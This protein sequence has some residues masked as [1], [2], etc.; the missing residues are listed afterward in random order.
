MQNGVFCCV[1]AFF[2]VPLHP[3]LKN[4][5]PGKL[6]DY[7]K[8]KRFYF[9]VVSF[10]IAS[11]CAL[12]Q[13]IDISGA[14]AIVNAA[15]Q[16]DTTASAYSAAKPLNDASA[17]PT[18][19]KPEKK[20]TKG[21][22]F[23]YRTG[24][25]VDNYLQR[26]IDTSYIGLPE[27][28]WR[29]AYTNAMV[30][31]N[32]ALSSS[33]IFATPEGPQE[34]TFSLL[35]RTTPSVDLGFYA[36]YRGFGFGY[37][38]DALHAYAQ[39]LS[40]SF[41]SKFIGID[42]AIQT[43]TNIH[44]TITLNGTPHPDWIPEKPDVV[45]TNANLNVWYALNAKHYSHQAAVKQSFIQKKTAGSFLLHLAYMSSQIHIQDTMT[46]PG[47]ERPLIPSMMN[48]ITALR[49]RQIAVGIGY[50][51]NYTPN[52]GKVVLHASA[53]AMLVTY[54]VNLISFHIPD[55][56]AAD[57]PGEPMYNLQP[58]DPVHVTGNMRA[59]ISWEI[60][61]WVHLSAWATKSKP[62][63][64]ENVLSLDNWNW[65]VQLTVGVRFGAGRD[66]V[67]RALY[68]NDASKLAN[69]AAL[70]PNDGPKKSRVPKWITDFFWSPKD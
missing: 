18:T 65:K 61:K 31:V 12:A 52:H 30:G 54:T 20:P 33:S 27:H 51:I 6:A 21:L 62:T 43:S 45:I 56:V 16:N 23:F 11:T 7:L 34:I 14:G 26:G 60:N 5:P 63:A 35:N 17:Q 55:S 57:L 19:Q 4:Y 42:F 22:L 39:R 49:T 68:G 70:Q 66:R 2:V 32:S 47:A 69:D 58:M 46:I 29:L 48:G 38:W 28:S 40:F 37:S 64:R 50:G 13:E 1:C 25:W 36:G 41:G 3:I 59:A 8:M 24:N 67:Q 44:S 53:A 9:I 15:V 10:I